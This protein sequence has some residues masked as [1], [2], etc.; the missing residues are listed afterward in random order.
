MKAAA[1]WKNVVARL[2]ILAVFIINITCALQFVLRPEVFTAAYQLTGPGAAAAVQGMGVVFAMWNATYPPVF[3]K[4]EKHRTLFCVM[5]AQQLTGLVGESWILF[6]LG[7]GQAV[8]AAS[9]ERFI[10]FDAGG[11]A[12]L[13]IAFFLTRR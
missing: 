12:V 13:L 7:A 6:G 8:L 3:L 11:L 5:I 2:L 9:I 1:S 4:P 10:A